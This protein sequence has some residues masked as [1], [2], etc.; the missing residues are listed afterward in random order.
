MVELLKTFEPLVWYQVIETLQK[1]K[2]LDF[3]NSV[4][5]ISMIIKEF[6]MCPE[7]H[8]RF[9]RTVS[10]NTID[11]Y[12]EK[13]FRFASNHEDHTPFY[14]I[15]EMCITRPCLSAY[16]VKKLIE[17]GH[18]E[19]LNVSRKDKLDASDKFMKAAWVWLRS[20]LSYEKMHMAIEE[21]TELQQIYLHSSIDLYC[22]KHGWEIE[23]KFGPVDEQCFTLQSSTN[24]LK[25]IE[26]IDDLHL[27][28]R[29][30]VFKPKVAITI[31]E[32]LEML[33]FEKKR[34]SLMNLSVDGI[35]FL[36]DMQA[37]EQAEICT[38]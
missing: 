2:N 28:A 33:P 32:N 5:A 3:K 38:I 27:M 36:I 25:L 14:S 30:L 20:G 22:Q 19:T 9:F 34:V 26:N 21:F 15:A 31:E 17:L 4:N 8:D 7:Q 11:N 37:F 29:T 6:K 12:L 16:L 24:E 23:D 10:H 18:Q 1:D 13:C 35:T